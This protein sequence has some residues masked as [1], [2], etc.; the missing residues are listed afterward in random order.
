MGTNSQDRLLRLLE[1]KTLTGY[2]R[3][4]IYRKMQ[5]GSFPRPLKMG[6]RAVGWQESEIVT[7]RAA[8][9]RADGDTPP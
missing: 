1:V 4:S 2:S 7:W 3:S 6:A 8:C 5:D 9:P